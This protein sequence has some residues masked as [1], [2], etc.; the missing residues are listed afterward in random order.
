MSSK[1]RL[2]N[3]AAVATAKL[4]S[5]AVEQEPKKSPAKKEVKKVF[6]F[7]GD[8]TKVKAW[9]L[10]ASISGQKV[11]DLGS[12]AMEEYLANHPL[13]DLEKKLFD[14]RMKS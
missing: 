8:E 2:K 11:D 4:F 7:R 5:G 3:S 14:E 6:S 9:R 10:Y 1:D 12:L 13:E